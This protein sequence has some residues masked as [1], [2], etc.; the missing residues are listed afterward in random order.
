MVWKTTWSSVLFSDYYPR[1]DRRI[2]NS[3]DYVTELSDETRLIS[4]EPD[5]SQSRRFPNPQ[6]GLACSQ[7]RPVGRLA[8]SFFQRHID[9]S[10][11]YHSFRQ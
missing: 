9:D 6:G 8:Q 5:R 3:M 4:R 1:A 7:R 11:Y 10:A 2:T